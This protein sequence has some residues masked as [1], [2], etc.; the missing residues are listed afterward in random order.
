MV[1]GHS[2]HLAEYQARCQAMGL[3]DRVHFL[4]RQADMTP[5]Y[6]AANLLVHPTREDTFGMVALEAMAQGVPVIVSRAPYCG[7]S[8]ELSADEAL[9]LNDPYAADE[10]AAALQSLLDDA[11]RRDALAKAGRKVAA[12][13]DWATQ[14]RRYEQ[15][16]FELLA[17]AS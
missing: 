1:V 7:L 3:A 9:L 8:A 10:L 4:G 11:A 12:R 13:Y 2:A 15:L 16:Y 6:A 5:L 17:G 14:A